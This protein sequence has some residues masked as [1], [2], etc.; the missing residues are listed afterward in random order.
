VGDEKMLLRVVLEDNDTVV[1][2]YL[3]SHNPLKSVDGKYF[4]EVL[5]G[6]A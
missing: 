2:A 3:T 4:A 5:E 1:M 6:W